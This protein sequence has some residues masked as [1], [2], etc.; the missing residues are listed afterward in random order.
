MVEN[1]R[2]L[3]PLRKLQPM[4][5]LHN[6]FGD[7]Q[8]GH[9]ER[10]LRQKG[11]ITN[12]LVQESI[13]H[14]K[15]IPEDEMFAHGYQDKLTRSLH[16]I[17]RQDTVGHWEPLGLDLLI[18]AINVLGSKSNDQWLTYERY[19]QQALK[20]F[21]NQTTMEA[22]N[23]RMRLEKAANDPV[24]AAAKKIQN[25]AN[26]KAR[27]RGISLEVSPLGA[28]VPD[29]FL[30]SK[31]PVLAGVRMFEQLALIDQL[32]MDVANQTRLIHETYQIGGALRVEVY[33]SKD[34]PWDE[35]RDLV[36]LYGSDFFTLGHEQP[37]DFAEATTLFSILQHT[38]DL[39][40][41]SF[42]QSAVTGH[43][44]DLIA[45]KNDSSVT[46]RQLQNFLINDISLGPKYE[47][48][49]RG[50]SSDEY[51][52][53]LFSAFEQLNFDDAT[54]TK[55][56]APRRQKGQTLRDC[57]LERRK[58]ATNEND[59]PTPTALLW[60]LYKVLKYDLIG[61]LFGLSIPI[62]QCQRLMERVD[63]IIEEGLAPA[64][65]KITGRPYRSFLTLVN[66]LMGKG[67]PDD[68]KMKE[69]VIQVAKAFE[70]T[71]EG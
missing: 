59:R 56:K 30:F 5:K 20:E 34:V 15:L 19:R 58:G 39:G 63:R 62:Y 45:E 41:Y 53:G 36:E 22:D 42:K 16:R 10:R 2:S 1:Y 55:S 38:K 9:E 3:T 11:K 43:L 48:R 26:R 52:D 8:P 49:N 23:S 60:K 31:N 4:I 40:Q 37:Q 18:D 47:E 35:L 51:E 13:R 71:M 66:L 25:K 21:R 44:L 33:I 6:T 67:G 28:E 7:T 57:V 27:R 46:L 64:A 54:V 65:P 14:A 24:P 50:I 68:A 61:D 29:F 32:R 12:F 70:E 69:V 17:L